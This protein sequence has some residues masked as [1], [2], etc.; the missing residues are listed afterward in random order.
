MEEIDGTGFV[1]KDLALVLNK[2]PMCDLAIDGNNLLVMDHMGGV[3][4]KI[5][6]SN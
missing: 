3:L 1:S 4:I 2:Y 5:T 6:L